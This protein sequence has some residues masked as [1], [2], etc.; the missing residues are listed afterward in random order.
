MKLERKV[1]HVRV[2]QQLGDEEKWL[3]AFGQAVQFNA[4]NWPFRDNDVAQRILKRQQIRRRLLTR[5]LQG[6]EQL[7]STLTGEGD[8]AQM[9]LKSMPAQ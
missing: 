8:Q 2:S 5:V 9:D 7:L 6:Y 1:I 4:G 3:R